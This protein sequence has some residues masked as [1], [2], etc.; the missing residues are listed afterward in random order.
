MLALADYTL[1]LAKLETTKEDQA[2]KLKQEA[3]ALLERLAIIDSDRKER[4]AD[5]GGS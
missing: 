1:L 2:G 4:Y 3:R 5:L